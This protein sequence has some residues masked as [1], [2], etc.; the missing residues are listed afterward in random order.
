VICYSYLLT[1]GHSD[2]HFRAVTAKENVEDLSD[3]DADTDADIPDSVSSDGS[4]WCTAA[5]EPTRKKAR[6]QS[7]SPRE[8]STELE[9]QP[10]HKY[11]EKASRLTPKVTKLTLL[12]TWFAKIVA[13]LGCNSPTKVDVVHVNLS[14]SRTLCSPI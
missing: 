5:G 4:G 6:V 8:G 1:A 9:D 12:T 7:P 11:H 2:H 3:S 14:G 10:R 13:N